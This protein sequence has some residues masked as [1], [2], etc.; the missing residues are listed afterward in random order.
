MTRSTARSTPLPAVSA[1][2][3]SKEPDVESGKG[4]APRRGLSIALRMTLWYA[5][6]T[7]TLIAVATGALYSVL[8]TTMYQE[9]LRDLADNLNNARLLLRSSAADQFARSPLQRPSWAPPHQPEIYLRVLDSNGR[10]L[11]ETPGMGDELPSP[12]RTELAS[13]SSPTGDKRDALSNS[14]KPFM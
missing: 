13:I 6:S 7:F 1:M 4:S 2:S 5:L 3:S 14:G 8:T 11:T 9:D 12:S 10:T